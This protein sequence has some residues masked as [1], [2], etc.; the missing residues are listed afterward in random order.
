MLRGPGEFKGGVCSNSK[1]EGGGEERVRTRNARTSENESQCQPRRRDE[2]KQRAK[3]VA[4][5]LNWAKLKQR[6]HKM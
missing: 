4:S 1:K 2:M 6:S 3:S 5:A